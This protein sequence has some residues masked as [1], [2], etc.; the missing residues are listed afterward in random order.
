M[1]CDHF[2]FDNAGQV[3]VAGSTAAVAGVN[4]M[5]RRWTSDPRVRCQVNP[6]LWF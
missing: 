2:S 4:N 6:M 3:R 5:K 1:E